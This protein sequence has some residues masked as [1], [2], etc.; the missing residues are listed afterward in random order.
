MDSKLINNQ[1]IHVKHQIVIIAI[2]GPTCSGKTTLSKTLQNQLSNSIIL[3][4]D[5]FVPN[6]KDIPIHPIHKVPDWDDPRGA[7]DWLRLRKILQDLK[8]LEKIQETFQTTASSSIIHQNGDNIDIDFSHS[9]FQNRFNQLIQSIHSHDHLNQSTTNT[10]TLIQPPP[11]SP[12]ADQHLAFITQNNQPTKL[13]TKFHYV[14]LDGFLLFW[15]LDCFKNYDLKFFIRESYQVLKERRRL[16][17]LY[18]TAEGDTWVDPP[19]YW[20]QIVWPAYLF[21]H[22]HMFQD[23]NVETGEFDQNS[24][25]GASTVLLVPD[26]HFAQPMAHS[27]VHTPA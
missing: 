27:L 1:I 10:Q 23:E 8:E 22:Q 18:Y 16:R 24:W 4:Q 15:D 12:P 14:I 13:I 9:I 7:I 17:Q 25:A 19:N 2:G 21:A 26:L 5:D 20:D 11:K 3:H 6:S